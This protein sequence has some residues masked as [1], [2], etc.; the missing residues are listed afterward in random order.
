MA[1]LTV[2]GAALGAVFERLLH[3]VE[4]EIR[5]AVK[6][7][8]I[9]NKIK[10]KL[11][12]LKPLVDE[13]SNMNNELDLPQKE[14][15]RLELKMIQGV[16]LVEACSDV[17]NWEVLK[18]RSCSKKLRAWEKSLQGPME[19][20]KLQGVRD[21]KLIL[22]YMQG[23]DGRINKGSAAPGDLMMV[24]GL[25]SV[26]DPPLVIV[27][28]DDSLKDL[29]VELLVKDSSVLVLT[30]PGGSGKTTLA[31]VFCQDYEVKEKFNIFFVK[32]TKKPS[33]ELIVH[34]LF[35]HNGYEAP[36]IQDKEEALNMLIMFLKN[37]GKDHPILLVLDDVWSRPESESLLSKLAPTGKE[38]KI[39]V[40]S[41]SKLLDFPSYQLEPLHHED[42]MTLFKHFA[43]LEIGSNTR[44]DLVKEM[45]ERCKRFP[46]ALQVTGG[47]LRGRP[48][49]IW[50]SKLKEWSTG[51]SILNTETEL[52]DRLKSSLDFLGG[53]NNIIKECFFDLGAFPEDVMIPAAA[54][55]DIWAE[56]H[57]IKQDA[58]A[59]ANLQ[60]LNTRN[61]TNLVVT[62]RDMDEGDCYYSEH[63]V[64]QHDILRD[65]AIHQS[66]EDP[67]R[68][69]LFMDFNGDM[70]QN[71]WSGQNGQPLNTRLLSI[72]TDGLFSSDWSKLQ[73]L[74]LPK[75]E[76][77]VLNIETKNYALPE[78]VENVDE[79]KVLI[80]TNFGFFHADIT[81]FQL[82]ISF[83]NLKRI[84]L[85]RI[86][87]YSLIEKLELAQLGN[88]QKISLFMCKF[89]QAFSDLGINISNIFPNLVEINIDYCDDLVEL[90][91]GLC[92]IISL[93]KL[94]ITHCHKLSKL[95]EEI[96]KL[97]NLEVL[98]LRS[99]IDL[100]ELPDS[101]C[102]LC[103]LT[104][105]DISDC[106]SLQKLPEDI[107]QLH[108]LRTLNTR[109]CSRFSE[110]PSSIVDLE[111]LKEVIC[112]EELKELWDLCFPDSTGIKLRLVKEDI[113]LNWL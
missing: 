96:G 43:S 32:F 45:V 60:E 101:I 113:N 37:Q 100:T 54:L 28:L 110:L 53:K 19:L 16:E 20:L 103:N 1:L 25:C 42:A 67:E 76:V 31:T 94:S 64:T 71:G 35:Q 105:L 65:L 13:I 55:I 10:E 72:S 59:I 109:S 91:A 89:D 95:P 9:L 27:G 4:K 79:L 5:A 82:L 75:P 29:K 73:D 26:P 21:G 6:F 99:C 18:R 36:I 90:P 40:T 30:G 69:R 108:R 93:K 23:W 48:G 104:F 77:L 33:L 70:L 62:R 61:L 44:D 50:Q 63:F 98:R 88:L 84:R 2:G 8:S 111:Q 102:N 46:L 68:K 38:Y 39:L 80:I 74:T 12:S 106:F 86:A 66:N 14:M 57:G 22:K 49:E 17:K 52:L 47:A 81:N 41:R 3:A 11:E 24:K 7:K 51:S 15:K 92:D 107:G 87:I 97:V 56:L 34:R 78:F 85:E 58:E 112:D 83:P